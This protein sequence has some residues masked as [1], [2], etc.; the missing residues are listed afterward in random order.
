M[1]LFYTLF[2]PDLTK[3]CILCPKIDARC[4]PHSFQ[5]F[6]F[7]L[8]ARTKKMKFKFSKIINENIKK[9]VILIIIYQH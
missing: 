5:P 4:K 8:L 3:F 1:S 7:V 2:I 6:Q 9:N